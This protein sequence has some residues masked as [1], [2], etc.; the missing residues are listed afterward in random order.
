MNFVLLIYLSVVVQF[1]Q[2]FSFY[3]FCFEGGTICLLI[4]RGPLLFLFNEVVTTKYL[5]E[6]D[7]QYIRNTSNF[8][9][10]EN[11]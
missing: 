5:W 4:F 8:I 9:H 10:F 6:V 2:F 1:Y 7:T 3:I 11:I